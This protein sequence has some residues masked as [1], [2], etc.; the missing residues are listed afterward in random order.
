MFDYLPDVG[1]ELRAQMIQIYWIMIVPFAVLLLIFEFFKEQ[2]PNAKDI[3]RRIV[4]SILLLYS[5]DY[6]LDTI[7]IGTL[8]FGN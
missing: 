3:L 8:L 2:P 5:F 6:V 4:I 1:R 7:A